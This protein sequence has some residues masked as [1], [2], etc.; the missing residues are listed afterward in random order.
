MAYRRGFKTEAHA[1]AVEVRA[2]LGLAPIEPLDPFAL[3]AHLEIPV[4]P[5]SALDDRAPCV[6]YFSKVEPEAFSAVTVFAGQRRMIVYN[7]AHV[8]GRQCS[9]VAHELAHALLLHPP[10]PALHHGGCRNWN[11][12]LEDEANFLGAA[13]LVTEQATLDV[14]R[15]GEALADAA[16]RYGVTPRLMQWRINATGARKRIERSRAYRR[17]S[18]E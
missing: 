1:L 14:T 9:D 18:A 11:Q 17:C 15:R 7:D 2:E 8:R 16:A 10:A 12:D 5:L 13:L 3:A 6:S 4:L